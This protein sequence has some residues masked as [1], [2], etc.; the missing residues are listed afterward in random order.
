MTPDVIKVKAH[1]G[2]KLELEFADGSIRLFDVKPLLHYPAFSDLRDSSLFMKA[3]VQNGTVCRNEEID[4]SPDTLYLRGEVLN[5][6]EAAKAI[7]AGFE[8]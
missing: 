6:D 8:C 1:Q 3:H 7:S 4:I 2:T 5:G